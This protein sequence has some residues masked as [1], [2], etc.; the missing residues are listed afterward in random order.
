MLD[1]NAFDDLIPEFDIKRPPFVSI[2]KNDLKA[3]VWN[4][5]DAEIQF[6]VKV[7]IAGVATVT[8]IVGDEAPQIFERPMY[9]VG[10]LSGQWAAD[11]TLI[12]RTRAYFKDAIS[13]LTSRAVVHQ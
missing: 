9:M 13:V 6:N 1:K 5:A 11:E 2:V 7:D 8:I 4:S 12:E 3:F 10:M